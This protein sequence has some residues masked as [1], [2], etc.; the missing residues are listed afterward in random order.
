MAFDPTFGGMLLPP[1]FLID[2]LGVSWRG[3]QG[4]KGDKGDIGPPGPAGSTNTLGTASPNNIT[5]AGGTNPTLTVTGTGNGALV[6]RGLGTSGINIGSTT[7]GNVA[8]FL[9]AATNGDTLLITQPAAAGTPIKFSPLNA[10]SGGFNFTGQFAINRNWTYSGTNAVILNQPFA[11][12]ETISGT[13]ANTTQYNVNTL[14]MQYTGFHTSQGTYGFAVRGLVGAG[15]NMRTNVPLAVT[16]N[17]NGQPLKTTSLAWQPNHAYSTVGEAAVNGGNL[18]QVQVAGTSASSGGPTGTGNP[19]VDGTVQWSFEDVAANT[20]YQVAFAPLATANYNLGGVAG[21]PVG[22]NFGMVGGAGLQTGATFYVQN[23][24]MELDDFIQ[25]GASATRDATIQLVKEGGQGLVQDWGISFGGGVGHTWRNPLV[26][27][28]AVDPNGVGIRVHDES[29]GTI[30]TMAGFID[31]LMCSPTGTNTTAGALVT[32]GGGYILRSANAQWLG[33]GDHQMGNALFHISANAL[34]I[35]MGYQLLTAVGATSGGTNWTTGM[36]AVDD[37]G[38]VGIVTAAAG[39]PSS[40]NIAGQPK[41]YV[42]TASVP[43]GAVTWHAMTPNALIP[44]ATGSASVPT[45]FTTASET[46]TAGTTLNLGTGTA[47]AINIGSATG[48]VGFFGATAQ[49][50]NTGW[51]AMTGTPDKATAFA[52]STVTLAQLAGR[53]MSL[54]AAITALGAIGA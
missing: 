3:L 38:N 40:V 15:S 13:S 49:A 23:V 44:T 18:Y 48:L 37:F 45:N 9:A 41:T 24:C 33:S 22:S 52:T 34:T 42:A 46:Y 28:T 26:F 20:N 29:V 51:A 2:P 5:A 17:Q 16:A 6:L 10:A 31:C 4:A 43:G 35:D 47:T 14:T 32:G 7:S 27:Q 12:N 50:K 53:V 11:I 30:Q 8:Q 1:D 19:I 54:Q 39:V 36:V 25:P 21:A